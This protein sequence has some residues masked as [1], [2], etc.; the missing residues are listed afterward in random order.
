MAYVL[1]IDLGTSGPKVALATADGCILGSEIES[2]RLI[3]QGPHGVEQDPDEWWQAIVTA[4][5]RLLARGLAPVDAIAGLGVTSQWAGTVALDRAGRPLMN[6]MIW[7]DARGARYMPPVVGG[8]IQVQGYGA[9]RLRKWIQRT[10][11]APSQSGKDPLAHILFIRHERPDIYAQVDKFL[12]PKDYLNFRLTGQVAASYDSIAL[13][14]VTD[15]RDIN[16]IVYD[17]EL[18]ALATLERAQLPDLKRAVDVLGPLTAQAAAELGLSRQVPVIL[19]T[20]DL[21]SAAIGS[22]ALADYAPH[23]Y[24]G[25]SAWISCHL[26]RKQTDLLHNMATLPSAI[27]GRYFLVT[28][29]ETA[30]ACLAFLRDQLLFP[31]DALTPNGPPPQAYRLF[32]DLAAQAPA[33]SDGL[34]FTPWLNGERTPVDEHTLRGGFHNLG[35]HHSRAHLIRAV[36]EGVAYN[37]RWLFGYVE[38]FTRRELPALNFIGGGANSDVWCQILADVLGRDIR[39]MEAPIEANARGV[40]IL[41]AVGLGLTTFE[42]AARQ[43]AVKRVFRPN[44]THRAIYDELYAAFL[45]LYR[46]NKSLYA[47]LNRQG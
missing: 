22:G 11:G 10:G 21:H 1:A 38:K 17:G 6:A 45:T 2:T 41:T 14:W 39:Q 30:G 28:E 36:L 27:P 23:L 7:L 34:I 8:P 35:L 25:T 3:Q 37:T 12:E 33:G 16:R 4:T 24:I 44:P 20:P 9:G 43:V 31:A 42:A 18:L 46:R 47:R 26:P 15:N 40:A 5:Q 29:Q 32:D 13:H 19:G